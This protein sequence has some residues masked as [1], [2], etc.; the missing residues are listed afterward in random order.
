[1][2]IIYNYV[3]W[4]VN[5]TICMRIWLLS[6]SSSYFVFHPFLAVQAGAPRHCPSIA[7]ALLA[8]ICETLVILLIIIIIHVRPF[9]APRALVQTRCGQPRCATLLDIVY[10]WT[11]SPAKPVWHRVYWLYCAV[12]TPRNG[13][14]DRT[15]RTPPGYGPDKWKALKCKP[16]AEILE[17][18]DWKPICMHMY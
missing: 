2:Y 9:A 5:R 4:Y 18:L 15:P 8:I 7:L 16:S 17:H 1:M 14:F 6:N 13:G 10:T 12:Y 11:L 3:A